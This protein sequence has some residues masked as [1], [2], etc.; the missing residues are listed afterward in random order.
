MITAAQGRSQ[1]KKAEGYQLWA[2]GHEIG[3]GGHPYCKIFIFVMQILY[4]GVFLAQ[5]MGSYWTS[6]VKNLASQQAFGFRRIASHKNGLN[7]SIV[8]ALFRSI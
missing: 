8:T 4:S 6:I 5:E 2:A 1:P 7:K 3:A